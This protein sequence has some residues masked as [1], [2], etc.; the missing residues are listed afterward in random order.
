MRNRSIVLLVFLSQ[1]GLAQTDRL[2][3]LHHRLATTDDISSRAR[4]MFNIGAYYNYMNID[5][6]SYYMHQV[7]RNTSEDRLKAETL[8]WLCAL[9]RM[10]RP[11]STFYYG[12]LTLKLANEKAYHDLVPGVFNSLS[13]TETA[14]GNMP[15]ALQYALQGVKLAEERNDE[16]E[17]AYGL[18]NLGYV[19][20]HD[21]SYQEAIDTYKRSYKDFITINR[22]ANAAIMLALTAQAYATIGKP[23]SARDYTTRAL[24]LHAENPGFFSEDIFGDVFL[25]LG[26]T[27]RSLEYYH[28]SI[29]SPELFLSFNGHLEIAKIHESR[30]NIDSAVTYGRRALN[31]SQSS[32]FFSNIIEVSIFLSAIYESQDPPRAMFY[33]KNA[34]A[35]QDSLIA[36]ERSMAI[37]DFVSI[38]QL[39]RQQEL[40]EKIQIFRIYILSGSSF[41]LL[42][43]AFLLWRS[44]RQKQRSK[45]KTEI[46]YERL[47]NTQS[48][49]IHSE[50]MASLGELTA[51]IAHEIQNPLNFVNNFSD[52]NRELIDELEEE[53]KKGNVE[54]VTSIAND[55]RDN[56]S[57][58]THH[59]KRAEEIV[60]SMLQHS[61]GSDGEKQLTN[62]NELAD[63]YLR[64]AYHGLR[65]KDPSF[66]AEIKTNFDPNL[67]EINIVPQDIGRVLLN[68]LNNAFSAV[69]E[70]EGPTV[71]LKTQKLNNSI[72][73][74]ISDNGPGIPPDIRDKIFQPFFTTKPTGQGTGLGLSLSYDIVTKGHGGNLTLDTQ[75][76]DGTT[77]T[78][79]LPLSS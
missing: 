3:S 40:D 54:E 37:S 67:S 59:G 58:I 63:E 18:A 38:D 26:D 61:R 17:L 62:I 64:L 49:L 2:D 22:E 25:K 39:Q 31:I 48:Q 34:I 19:Y 43:L 32:G 33:A 12:R 28:R 16:F 29:Q 23:D 74:T 42:V 65:A 21:G 76:G 4:T 5:S 68:L 41:I 6:S 45:R 30:G 71:N 47:K 78:I 14:I 13:L 72:T 50:K 35:Y 66:N 70:V 51:G 69:S 73:I 1:F 75:G 44:Q 11:D 55:L 53:A 57:K 36:M 20:M 52:V 15:Q 46:A 79:E 7:L 77:F 60:K 9:Y 56:E 8:K 10:V 24:S 27:L